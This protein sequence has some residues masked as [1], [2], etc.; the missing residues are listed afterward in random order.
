MPLYPFRDQRPR[1]GA[2]V[3]LAPDAHV[4]GDVTLGD[5]VSFWF[6]AMA[7]GDVHRIRIGDATNV[8]DGSVLH[9]SYGTFPLTIG[10][11]VV[12]GHGAI[13][14]GCTLEDGCLIGI[15]A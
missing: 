8:Q 13:V 15:G 12:I 7:R 11:G 6:G 3:F 9:V 4:V 1:L 5:D 10:R 14:H 2:R